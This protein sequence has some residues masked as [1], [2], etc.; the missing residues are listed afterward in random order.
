MKIILNGKETDLPFPTTAFAL[1]DNAFAREDIVI[2]NGF[3]LRK[4][5][6]L[7]DGD[8]L[9]IIKKDV[10]P[11]REQLE[12][13]MA[14]RHTPHVHEKLKNAKVAI[15]GLGGLGSTIA[16]AL[17]RIGV[18]RLLLVDYDIVEPS[19]LN[20]QN[21]EIAD[22]GR[23]KTKALKDHIFRINPFIEV[24][25]KTVRIVKEEVTELFSGY[26]ILCEAFDDAGE[27]AMLV[28]TALKQLPEI[29]IV[30]ASGLAGYDS[31]NLHKA[32]D[33]KL[34]HLRRRYQ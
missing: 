8:T 16:L 25:T 17:A 29:K 13:M 26:E 21:Y 4:D 33:E 23:Y 12:A 30:A 28:N 1:R 7:S 15:A 31:S 9:F 22:L 32:E 19:N 34:V 14:A 24:K 10:L 18:G 11:P 27:K 20:R 3:Q 5:A 2:L 6:A